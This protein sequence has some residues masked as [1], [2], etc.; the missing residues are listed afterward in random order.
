MIFWQEKY[1]VDLR[2][3]VRYIVAYTPLQV[4]EVNF[5]FIYFF[6]S[7]T[8]LCFTVKKISAFF[9]MKRGKRRVQRDKKIDTLRYFFLAF[10]VI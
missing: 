2:K 8:L 4:L 5:H 1:F 7:L 10:S 6:S 3:D 9:M